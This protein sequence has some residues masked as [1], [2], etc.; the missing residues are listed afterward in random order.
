MSEASPA[1][2]QLL[3]AARALVPRIRAA[4]DEIE[5]ERALPRD[6]VAAL[7]AA[8]LFTQLVPRSV[9]GAELDLPS[10]SQVIQALAAADAST[11][12]CVSQACVFAMAAAFLPLV[13][14]R[15]IWS[16]QP[17]TVVANGPGPAGL[18][19]V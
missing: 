6:L 10:Y 3:Q 1:G 7:A 5:R 14:A 13:A 8:G 18:A 11:A 16:T 15:E 9:G 19:E 12:W 17:W 2:A 4:A